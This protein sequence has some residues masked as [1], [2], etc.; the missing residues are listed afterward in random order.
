MTSRLILYYSKECKHS[1]Q[2]LST[3]SQNP[4]VLN[5]FDLVDIAHNAPPKYITAVPSLLI[6]KSNGEADMLV[7]K[8]VFEW[9]NNLLQNNQQQQQHQQQQHQQQ[10]HPQNNNMQGNHPQ[11]QQQQDNGISD[12]D[13]CTMNGFSDNFSFLGDTNNKPIDHNFSFLN[14]NNDNLINPSQ[15]QCSNDSS[16]DGKK[17]DMER[18]YENFKNSRDNDIPQPIRRA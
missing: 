8:S 4:Q 17:S 16:G 6:P 9:V 15:F 12:F 3:F 18:A 14:N 10:Q 2:I 5:K 11:N 13:P 7:G 1:R